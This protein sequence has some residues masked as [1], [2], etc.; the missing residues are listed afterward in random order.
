MADWGVWIVI[1]CGFVLG[2]DIHKRV[3]RTGDRLEG[4][5][6]KIEELQAAI[7]R[8]ERR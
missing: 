3:C 8:L 5:E 4:Y 1:I 7:Y 2:F 6:R